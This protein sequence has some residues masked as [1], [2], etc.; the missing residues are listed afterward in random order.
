M[1]TAIPPSLKPPDTYI[2]L[3]ESIQE[4]SGP[5]SFMR[6]VESRMGSSNLGNSARGKVFEMAFCEVLAREGI[7]PFYYQAK[8]LLRP[9]VIYDILLFQEPNIPWTISLKTSFRERW[10][11]SYAEA[12]ILKAIY[13]SARNYLVT[14]DEREARLRQRD[15][16]ENL[17]PELT[18]CILANTRE[19]D[20]L[21]IKMKQ[22]RFSKIVPVQI[23]DGQEVSI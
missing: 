5:S 21:V 13:P 4:Y 7:V 18:G 2:S 14:L 15:I 9:I 3:I 16:A 6:Q 12:V 8:F 10:K 22:Q 17:V 11:Q 23:F 19:L 1:E 20:D